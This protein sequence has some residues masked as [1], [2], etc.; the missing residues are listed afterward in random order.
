M[1]YR[2]ASQ[3]WKIRGHLFGA[4]NLQNH[5]PRLDLPP[6]AFHYSGEKLTN[7]NHNYPLYYGWQILPKA[8][9][10]WAVPK[11]ASTAHSRSL[12]STAQFPINHPLLHP[13]PSHLVRLPATLTAG[14]QSCFTGLEIHT[15]SKESMY[16]TAP[17]V[18]WERMFKHL[19]RIFHRQ[20]TGE[21]LSKHPIVRMAR[22][23]LHCVPRQCEKKTS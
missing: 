20:R 5:E 3:M 1:I 12:T 13:L 4:R 10:Y 14:R 9:H 11:W 17:K 21:P 8:R 22:T 6:E 2:H 16:H 19:L 23:M 18:F 15:C 7:T